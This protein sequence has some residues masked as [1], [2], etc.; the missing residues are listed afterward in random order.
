[1]WKKMSWDFMLINRLEL[2]LPLPKLHIVPPGASEIT[3]LPQR[4]KMSESTLIVSKFKVIF[5]GTGEVGY[6]KGGM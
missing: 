5:S 1:M 3:P 6:V 4:R 2:P